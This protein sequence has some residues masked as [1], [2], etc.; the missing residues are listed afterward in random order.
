MWKMRNQIFKYTSEYKTV[1]NVFYRSC[2]AVVSVETQP[3]R[4]ITSVYVWVEN[5]P[6]QIIPLTYF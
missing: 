4:D 3:G 1:V 5:D 2:I 6:I